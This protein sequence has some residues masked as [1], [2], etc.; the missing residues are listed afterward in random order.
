MVNVRGNFDKNTE[1]IIRLCHQRLE[2]LNIEKDK[3]PEIIVVLNQNA[4]DKKDES[5]N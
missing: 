4:S 2:D 3:R 5:E 1:K